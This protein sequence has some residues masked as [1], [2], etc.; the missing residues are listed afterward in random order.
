M[1]Q[2]SELN[3]SEV[4]AILDEILQSGVEVGPD[5]QSLSKMAVKAQVAQT[6]LTGY[7]VLAS[8]RQARA[9]EALDKRLEDLVSLGDTKDIH[10]KEL[11]QKL[12]EI[13]IVISSNG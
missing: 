13:R 6:V 10:Q 3:E 7:S 12:D 11:I 2:S 4:K 1:P 5:S 8:L 9:L